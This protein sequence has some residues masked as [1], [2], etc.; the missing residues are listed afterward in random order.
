MKTAI[1]QS[2]EKIKSLQDSTENFAEKR[3]FA[4]AMDVLEDHKKMEKRL[5]SNSM[6]HGW[7]EA[8]DPS[9][10]SIDPN[11]FYNKTFKSE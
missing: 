2:I 5:M 7:R 11:D 6:L 4:I 10:G 3:A 1:Q 8:L 9:V